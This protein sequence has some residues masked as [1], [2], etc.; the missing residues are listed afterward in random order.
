M[1]SIREVEPGKALLCI[2]AWV[3]ETRLTDNVVL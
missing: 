1:E 3:D 2:A